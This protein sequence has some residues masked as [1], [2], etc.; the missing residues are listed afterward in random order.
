[1]SEVLV[2][3]EALQV[4]AWLGVIYAIWCYFT[5]DDDEG[6]ETPIDPEP[7]W[8]GWALNTTSEPRERELV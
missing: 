7:N 1:M 4:V 6:E 8:G 5:D 2:L 3:I